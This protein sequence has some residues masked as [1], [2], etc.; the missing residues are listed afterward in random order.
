MHPV[1]GRNLAAF[2]FLSVLWS[3]NWLSAAA[4]FERVT[5]RSRR[6]QSREAR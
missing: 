1:R 5:S 4:F 2:W 6:G 3:G